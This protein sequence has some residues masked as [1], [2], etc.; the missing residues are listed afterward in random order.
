MTGGNNFVWHFQCFSVQQLASSAALKLHRLT[1]DSCRRD[2]RDFI[3]RLS[4]AI[5]T[6]LLQGEFTTRPPRSRLLRMQTLIS[7]PPKTQSY[8]RFSLLSLS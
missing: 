6:R 3:M 2:L 4:S 8:E 1:A 7:P 5:I